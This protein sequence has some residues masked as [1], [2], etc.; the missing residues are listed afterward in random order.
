MVGHKLI[1]ASASP[2]RKDI[3]NTI[4]LKP[5]IAVA[6]I[7]ETPRKDEDPKAYVQRLAYEKVMEVA[8]EEQDKLI[9]GGDTIVVLDDEILQKPENKDDATQMLQ[10]LRNRR[11][12]VLT[13]ISIYNM[14]TDESYT[15]VAITEVEMIDY[16]D[17]MIQAYIATGEPMDKAGSYGIQ[18]IGAVLV[19][20]VI[21]DYNTVV[22]LPVSTLMEGFKEL[23]IDYFD[24]LDR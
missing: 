21:G 17:A 18:G 2:R 10:K 5:A 11:H 1:L 7:D 3:L 9:I 16:S 14:S 6:D 8:C 22:G 13:G 20:E 4:G 15:D 12:E 19:K 23:N 24:L